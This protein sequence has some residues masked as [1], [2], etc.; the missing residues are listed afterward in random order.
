LTRRWWEFDEDWWETELESIERGLCDKYRTG[1]APDDGSMLGA[2]ASV[3][4][5]HI[6]EA[7]RVHYAATRW[8]SRDQPT[9]VGVVGGGS[10]CDNSNRF[11]YHSS[12]PIGDSQGGVILAS[13]TWADDAMRWDSFDDHARYPNALRGLQEVYGQRIEV[14]YTGAGQTQS[15]LRDPYAYGEASVLLPGQH[16][17][18]FPDIVSP[19]GPLYFGGDHT[20][21]KTAW[22]EGALE[23]AVRTA[24]EV[25]LG[26]R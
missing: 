9:A 7:Q 17:Q 6:S 16:T 21:I 11:V 13:C 2:H 26:T 20:S 14:F 8:I 24:L 23:S 3:P 18:L 4:P 12:N 10:V 15:W 25:H 1:T 22:I 5:G 19:E